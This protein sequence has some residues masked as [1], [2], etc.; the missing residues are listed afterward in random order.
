MLVDSLRAVVARVTRRLPSISA[1]RKRWRKL[2]RFF[3]RLG[4]RPVVTARMKD[5]TC[6]TVDLRTRSQ[7]EPYYS[8]VYEA[9][10]VGAVL[11]L[12]DQSGAFLDVGAN[13]G[14]YAVAVARALEVRGGAGRVIC[15]EPL[16][17][18]LARL[19]ENLAHNRLLKRCT[20]WETG[21]SDRPEELLLTLRED[22][23]EGGG[24]GNASVAIN[25][26]HDAGFARVPIRLTT[27][28]LLWPALGGVPGRLDFIKLD[29]EGHEDRFFGG[30]TRTLAAER[31]AVLMEVNKVYYRAKGVDMDAAIGPCLPTNYRMY[32]HRRTR[33]RRVQSFA[34]C[35]GYDN[36]LLLPMERVEQAVRAGIIEA[37]PARC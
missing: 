27:L 29:I 20:L 11:A 3:N 35:P 25:E 22:F 34:E 26:S 28:D 19:T 32:L 6:L 2:N 16:P 9:D 17:A 12:Y 21:L 7:I 4:A 18:N 8:G 14:F 1:H 36:V 10:L 5:G 33:W 23:R 31:P 30:A 24:T 37:E 13:V 15:V